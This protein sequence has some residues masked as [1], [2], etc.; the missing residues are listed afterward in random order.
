[1]FGL[2]LQS[3]LELNFDYYQISEWAFERYMDP[4]LSTNEEVSDKILTLVVM[5]EGP[6]FVLS[7]EQLES[8]A[9]ELI[10]QQ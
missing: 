1:M 4:E 10:S 7:K 8:M 5:Q 3:K 2:E 9:K 6:E